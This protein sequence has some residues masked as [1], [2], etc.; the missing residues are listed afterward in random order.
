MV[1]DAERRHGPWSTLVNA[2][3]VQA[4]SLAWVDRAVQK[5][6]IGFYRESSTTTRPFVFSKL[7]VVGMR[8]FSWPLPYF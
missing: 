4:G 1:L 3:G 2:D 8:S 7:D 5:Q 6:N